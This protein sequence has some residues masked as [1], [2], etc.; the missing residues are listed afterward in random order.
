M[1]KP[2]VLISQRIPAN[3]VDLL[4]ETCD[5]DYNDGARLEP[6]ALHARVHGKAGVLTLLT[7][8]VDDAFL[9]AAGPQL[10]IVAN[11]AV[12]YDNIDVPAC[13]KRGVVVTNTPGV[14]DDATAD[15]AFTLLLA[16]ARGVAEA[17]RYVR[18]GAFTG[19]DMMGF[20][21]GDLADMTLGIAGFGRIGQAVARRAR[22]FGMHVIYADAQRAMP[23]HEA[24]VDARFVT[25]DEL[26]THSDYLSLHVP[27]LESTRH[28]IGA[29]ELRAMKKTAYL[30]NTSR[31]PV[32]N[33]AALAEALRTHEI[34][35]A[36][37]DVFEREPAVDTALFALDNVTLAPHIAS[38]TVRTRFN[39]ARIAAEN[40]AAVLGG[41]VPLT[42][43]G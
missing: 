8:R 18:S 11:V 27:L 30:I 31:G 4:K 1:T 9:D 21:G 22:G 25:K 16:A 3:G 34:A 40:V 6:A 38:A 24:A 29:A 2:S 20:H 32:V 37:L 23:E 28:Y 26:L 33:E 12:G 15:F 43:V 41:G 19:W 5:I 10:R 17:D 14:L 35:G 39:M 36:G 7:D 42:P 13:T